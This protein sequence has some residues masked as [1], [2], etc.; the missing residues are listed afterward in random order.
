MAPIDETEMLRTDVTE[1]VRSMHGRARRGATTTA[2][3]AFLLFVV[4]WWTAAIALTWVALAGEGG[5]VR[6]LL[7]MA[8][9]LLMLGG[10]TLLVRWV[11]TWG[12]MLVA[13]TAPHRAAT[14]R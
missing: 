2:L 12:R 4:P 6:T 14:R 13:F 1:M 10:F 11:R 9:A 5:G 8:V 3:R 7:L